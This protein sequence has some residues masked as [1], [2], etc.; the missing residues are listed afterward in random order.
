[1][2]VDCVLVFRFPLVLSSVKDA[3]KK[4]GRLGRSHYPYDR[5]VLKINFFPVIIFIIDAWTSL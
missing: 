2:M 4:C 1:M 5:I 3:I